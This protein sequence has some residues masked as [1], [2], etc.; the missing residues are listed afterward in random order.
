MK[1]LKSDSLRDFC[2]AGCAR[3]TRNP[4]IIVTTELV[5]VADLY[6]ELAHVADYCV[7]YASKPIRLLKFS[8]VPPK[9]AKINLISTSEILDIT[10][11]GVNRGTK[12]LYPR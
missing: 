5:H 12:L 3:D 10:L 4:T 1:I 8:L 9:V 11:K 7:I 6:V 2:E